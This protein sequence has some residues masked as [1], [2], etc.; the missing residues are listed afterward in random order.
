MA[1]GQMGALMTKLSGKIGG[2]T[3]GNTTA[4]LYVKNT[5]TYSKVN[6]VSRQNKLAQFQLTAQ[7]WATLSDVQAVSWNAAALGFPY[8]DRLGE[9]RF[10]SGY[11]LFVKFNGN[12]SEIGGTLRTA[13]P[14]PIAFPPVPVVTTTFS[15]SS[16]LVSFDTVGDNQFRYILY[17][18]RS[19]SR[20]RRSTKINYNKIVVEASDIFF[21]GVDVLTAYSAVF[22]APIENCIIHW[23][24]KCVYRQTGQA[25]DVVASGSTAVNP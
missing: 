4:G 13:P 21:A 1:K 9:Q 8:V 5:G 25:V 14:S 19:V 12:L 2:Q 17:M 15:T 7:K 16:L 18:S 24:I 6:S 10:Y 11:Q 23:K 20:G 22:G 3:V